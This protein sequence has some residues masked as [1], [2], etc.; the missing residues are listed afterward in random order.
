MIWKDPQLEII[1]LDY[2]VQAQND[3]IKKPTIST[4]TNSDLNL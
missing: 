2:T 1:E 3:I 4:E